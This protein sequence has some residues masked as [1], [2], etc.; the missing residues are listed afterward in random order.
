M[1]QVEG[2]DLVV[3]RGHESKP[4]ESGDTTRDL[5]LVDG[6]DAALKLAQV[7]APAKLVMH[8]DRQFRKGKPR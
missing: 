1:E 6:Y 5:N 4:K 3:N 2:G 7:C 8:T